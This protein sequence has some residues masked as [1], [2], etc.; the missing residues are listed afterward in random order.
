[1]VMDEVLCLGFQHQHV[2]AVFVVLARLLTL[3]IQKPRIA[4]VVD[5]LTASFPLSLFSPALLYSSLVYSFLL[6]LFQ[7][8]STEEDGQIPHILR[9]RDSGP[10]CRISI[11]TNE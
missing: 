8:V 11:F 4:R 1:M 2:C 3:M 5:E 9:V 7:G 6:F 10:N